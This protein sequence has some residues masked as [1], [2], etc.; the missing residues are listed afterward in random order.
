MKSKLDGILQK[1]TLVYILLPYVLFC[2]T[3]LKL[4]F[5]IPLGGLAIWIIYKSFSEI[6]NDE[7]IADL[8]R[9][10]KKT[11]LYIFLIICVFMFFS[12][13][14]SYTFQNY[15]HLY[16]NAIFRD[17]VQ[18]PWPVMY[19]I[20]GF[21]TH[22]FEGKTTMMTYY[23]GFFLPA[24]FIGKYLG[25]EAGKA[26][27][28]LW[29]ILGVFLVFMHVS[30][31]L[32]RF[33]YKSLALFLGWGTLFFIGAL[34]KYPLSEILQEK[35]WLWAG[36]ILYSD[37]NIGMIYYTFNQGIMSWL[38]LMLLMQDL[39]PRQIIFWYSLCFFLSPFAFVGMAPFVLYSVFKDYSKARFFN[40]FSIE[41][42]AGA[43]SVIGLTYLYLSN[44]QAGQ[45][46]QVL[47]HRPKILFVFLLLSWGFVAIL[48][49]PKYKKNGLYWLIIAVLLPLPFFQQGYGIDFPGR[50]SIP[51]LSVLMLLVG[52]NII[53]SKS[54]WIK[55]GLISYMLISGIA[56]ILLE[57]VRSLYFTGVEYFARKG[58]IAQDFS[59][60][61]N[62][63][64]KSVGFEMQASIQKPTCI[65]DL[66]TLSNPKNE[67]IWNYM[68]DIETSR[69][70]R[71]VAKK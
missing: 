44:N 3:W 30:R 38:I 4:I 68:S 43:L 24:A 25:F 8:I 70:Y 13:I 59:N 45:F 27:L 62:S 9:S 35:S 53:E 26:A 61:E 31:Y 20:K 19:E 29:S 55:R 65:K 6:K 42:I 34:Y 66:G 47:H 5:A 18:K 49:F 56:H 41:N 1:T 52:K 14:G 64:L 69:F 36:M 16:R 23:M 11:L 60:S 57:P 39:V 32:K 22:I 37:S 58:N 48:L 54:V 71:W 50:L 17:L 2:F 40:Y 46:F 10:Q 15:D 33:T 12:G 51:A 28:L 63:V 67:V 21:G 7:S